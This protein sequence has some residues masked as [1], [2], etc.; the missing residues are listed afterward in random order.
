MDIS[1]VIVSYNASEVLHDCLVS[2]FENTK[3]TTYEVVVVDNGSVDGSPDMVEDIFPEVNLLRNDK[4]LGFSRANNK[5]YRHSR[6][7]HLL[8][9]NSDTLVLDGAIEKMFE[10]LKAH[11]RVG[12]VGPKILNS[13]RQPTRSY[14]RFLDIK[15]L[16]LGSKRFQ[17]IFEFFME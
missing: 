7:K 13:V 14:M 16:F 3:D 4:N 8:F 12:I 15:K 6:G 9:L 11:S 17:F 2:I 1:I 10:Y 5:G